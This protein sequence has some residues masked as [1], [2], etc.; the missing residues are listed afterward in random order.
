MRGFTNHGSFISGHSS[1]YGRVSLCIECAA[2]RDARS[3]ASWI[4]GLVVILVVIL[5]A[6]VSN[7]NKN[8]TEVAPP[9]RAPE[10]KVVEQAGR[11]GKIIL[12]HRVAIL[13]GVQAW[14]ELDDRKIA[15]WPAGRKEIE[16]EAPA[17]NY[18]MAVYSTYRGKTRS[19]CNEE[20]VVRPN[21]TVSFEILVGE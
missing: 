21:E 6:C 19:M 13:N 16:F 11:V 10:Q 20:I 9:A 15:D 18:R 12:T 4:T 7:V 1:N 14:V 8:P 17:G 3:R 2:D 5:V